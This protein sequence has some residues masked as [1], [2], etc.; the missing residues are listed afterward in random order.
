MGE[1][2]CNQCRPLP[3]QGIQQGVQFA[4]RQIVV[5]ELRIELPGESRHVQIPELLRVQDLRRPGDADDPVDARWPVEPGERGLRDEIDPVVLHRRNRLPEG[6]VKDGTVKARVAHDH[7]VR[8]PLCHL[9][10]RDRCH[11]H[12]WHD[13]TVSHID[14]A[15]QF[16]QVRMGRARRVGLESLGTFGVIDPDTLIC[17]DIRNPGGDVR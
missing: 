16:D 11:A 7:H 17:G 12:A 1:L 6:V 14:P 8:V 2:P 3:E 9:F 10:H 13:L 4:V 15:G 5:I